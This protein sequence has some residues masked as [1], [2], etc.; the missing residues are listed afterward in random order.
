MRTTWETLNPDE[1]QDAAE[2]EARTG[3]DA[4]IAPRRFHLSAL[5]Y[6]PAYTEYEEHVAGC[7][8]C[9]QDELTDCP[10]GEELFTLARIGL[11]EQHRLAASN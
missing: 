3:F 4:L 7:A 5:P 8:V 1:M 2:S 6:F 11:S 9:Q 10:I